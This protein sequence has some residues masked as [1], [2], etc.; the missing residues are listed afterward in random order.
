MSAPFCVDVAVVSVDVVVVVTVAVDV[1]DKT[2]ANSKLQRI[3]STAT[4]T[5]LRRPNIASGASASLKKTAN[6]YQLN[7]YFLPS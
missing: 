7:R 6:G 3:P 1:V 2:N 4:A 5:L